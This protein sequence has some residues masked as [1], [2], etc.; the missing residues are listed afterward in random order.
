MRFFPVSDNICSPATN[1]TL[2]AATEDGED[3]YEF[4]QLYIQTGPDA[5]QYAH[6][7]KLESELVAKSMWTPGSCL[8]SLGK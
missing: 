2:T 6:I 7:H 8:T 3:D 5:G 4:S 1:T